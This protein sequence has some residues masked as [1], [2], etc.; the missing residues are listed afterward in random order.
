MT[1]AQNPTLWAMA[2]LLFNMA[3][4]GLLY[5][6]FTAAAHAE[7]GADRSEP[8]LEARAGAALLLAGFFLQATGTA[9]SHALDPAAAVVLLGLALTLIF[10]VAAGRDTLIDAMIS[11]RVSAGADTRPQLIASDRTPAHQLQ[12]LRQAMAVCA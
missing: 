7:P 6:A 8:W 5:I 12:D 4:A 11:K 10:Y 3:G 9:G 1:V 2:G